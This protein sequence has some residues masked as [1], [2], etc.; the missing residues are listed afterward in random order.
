MTEHQLEKIHNYTKYKVVEL[1]INKHKEGV[2]LKDLDEIENLSE[3]I[4][5]ILGIVGAEFYVKGKR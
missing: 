4:L 1:L 3:E 5:F 2:T